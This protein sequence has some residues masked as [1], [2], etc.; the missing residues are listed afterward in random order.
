MKFTVLGSGAGIPSRTRNTQSYI[1]D[2]VEEINQYF[3]IDAAEGVQHRILHTS[4]RPAKVRH[5]LI[6]HLHGDH[7]FCL[8]VFLAS[9]AS[10]CGDETA[11]HVDVP[12]G[13]QEWFV[14]SVVR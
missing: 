7:I 5:V 4:V 10:T 8:P 9:R 12:T 6:T 13:V 2:I 3:L 11:L 1:L 14:L